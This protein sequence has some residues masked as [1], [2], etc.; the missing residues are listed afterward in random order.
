[1]QLA[2]NDWAIP[3]HISLE[4]LQLLALQSGTPCYQDRIRRIMSASTVAAM[5]RLGTQRGGEGGQKA[6]K[7]D[8]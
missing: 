6:S 3:S 7:H 4:F 8:E 5:I 2:S 1:M